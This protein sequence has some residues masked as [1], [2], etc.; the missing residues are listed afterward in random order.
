MTPIDIRRHFLA[1]HFPERQAVR[2]LGLIGYDIIEASHYLFA[3][4]SS[5]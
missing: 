5:I 3:A 2:Y 1:G 4:S